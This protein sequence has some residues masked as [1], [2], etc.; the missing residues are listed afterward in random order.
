MGESSR[1]FTSYCFVVI[2]V[3]ACQYSQILSQGQSSSQ[4]RRISYGQRLSH[5]QILPRSKT[6]SD[7]DKGLVAVKGPVS[8][9]GFKMPPLKIQQHKSI[10]I[11]QED[12]Y[13]VSIRT[14]EHFSG[15]CLQ[16]QLKIINLTLDAQQQ[17]EI[18]SYCMANIIEIGGVIREQWLPIPRGLN[19]KPLPQDIELPVHKYIRPNFDGV[20]GMIL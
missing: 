9:L 12:H 10:N 19:L 13:E 1:G 14:F 11:A 8:K 15:H 17:N 2:A 16:L 4:H 7:K 3:G 20:L 5:H 6:R 18:L